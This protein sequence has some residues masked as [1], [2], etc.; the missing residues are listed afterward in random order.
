MMPTYIGDLVIAKVNI[1][2]PTDAVCP[3]KMPPRP[4]ETR[5]LNIRASW[6]VCPKHRNVHREIPVAAAEKAATVFVLC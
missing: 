2:S 6:E 4:E 5:F 3:H 1:Y